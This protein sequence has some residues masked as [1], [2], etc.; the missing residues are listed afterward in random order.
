[1]SVRLAHCGR[2]ARVLKCHKAAEMPVQ[3]RFTPP[4]RSLSTAEELEPHP[5]HKPRDS[6]LEHSGVADRVEQIDTKWEDPFFGRGENRRFS[7]FKAKKACPFRGVD[8]T[9]SPPQ[10]CSR[11]YPVVQADG[12]TMSSATVAVAA[13]SAVLRSVTAQTVASERGVGGRNFAT[14]STWRARITTIYGLHSTQPL[15]SSQI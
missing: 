3:M 12:K 2:T 4:G 13:N 1:M 10:H 9:L 14:K 8:K 7:T 11:L 5:Y 15:T 6:F